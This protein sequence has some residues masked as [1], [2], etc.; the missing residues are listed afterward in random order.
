M[1]DL[2]GSTVLV[3]GVTGNV[4]WGAAKAFL[5]AGA[6]VV[7]PTRS[8]AR[9]AQL[10]EEFAGQAFLPLAADI[11][12]EAGAAALRDQLLEHH[13]AL[14]HLVAAI[15]PWWQKGPVIEQSLGELRAVMATYL[16]SQFLVAKAFVPV[17]RNRPGAS[18]TVVTGAAGEMPVPDAGFVVTAAAGLFGLSI[19]LRAEHQ[20]DPFRL[21]E[22]RINCRIEREP[23]PGVVPSEVAGRAFVDLALSDTHGKVVRYEGPG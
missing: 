9:A 15:G 10:A 5:A 18:Y 4:G 19:M 16:E 12:T 13:D 2:E 21:N 3:F 7:A 14:D 11:S 20:D 17:L 23:R 6:K 1:S 8:A 22:F